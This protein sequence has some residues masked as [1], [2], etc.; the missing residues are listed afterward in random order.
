MKKL[1]IILLFILIPMSL[2]GFYGDGSGRSFID[3]LMDKDQLRARTDQ[4]GFLYGTEHIRVAFGV[5][6]NTSGVILD[7]WTN[8]SQTNRK[9]NDYFRPSVAL[10]V[11]Y[12]SDLISV[13]GAYQFK[14]VDSNYMVH[15]PA[16]MLTA[17]DNILRLNIPV[18]IGIGNHQAKNTLV[19]STAIEARYYLHKFIDYL[20]QLRL[21]V[22]YGY[23]RMS[24]AKIVSSA[25]EGVDPNSKAIYKDQTSI[26]IDLRAY[27]NF[28][29]DKGVSIEPYLRVLYSAA[30]DTVENLGGV[31]NRRK[32]NNFN[33]NAYG[34]DYTS[35]S[36]DATGTEKLSGGY[37]AS[38]PGIPNPQGQMSIDGI[39][40]VG[41]ALPLGL[42]ASNDFVSLYVEP[43]LAVTIF[44]G[45][46]S[47]LGVEKKGFFYTFGYVVY[48]ELTVTPVKYLELF[49]ELQ[50]GGAS[51][52][53][54]D[55]YGASATTMILNASSGIAWYF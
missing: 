44:G 11:G 52:L 13:G 37:I 29:T 7:N 46:I 10:A 36:F 6:G 53:G 3:F 8:D 18:A 39:Y 30:L 40:R 42:R 54:G 1:L 12:K 5:T 22:Y 43:S 15:T 4:I 20:S 16:L 26:G 48:S 31:L 27:F 47:L 55:L 9:L 35:L 2:F 49:L 33:I 51:R 19:V 17:M 34:F 24:Y 38:V 23:A 50:T 32:G 28:P 21:Y 45:K 14:Y 41:I 25:A